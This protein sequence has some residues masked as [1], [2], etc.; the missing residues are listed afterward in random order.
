MKARV[1]LSCSILLAMLGLSAC[2]GAHEPTNVGT[3]IYEL[4][5]HGELDA[6][7]P[8][9]AT[10]SM[11]RVGV[12]SSGGVL[13]LGVPNDALIGADARVSLA[14]SDGWS[15]A[16]E[17]SLR[18]CT[19]ATLRREWSVVR[20]DGDSFELVY[21]EEWRGLDTCGA[22]MRS[23][24]PA[25]PATDCRAELV[26]DYHRVQRCEAPCEVRIDAGGASCACE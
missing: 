10:G 19:E 23:I 12:V 24:M 18:S 20:G 15:D 17:E 5:V 6:C 1:S 3:G 7:S 9:R 4:T 2:A 16:V 11:G 8:M 26:L 21:A 22:A 13:N 14:Q 25:A